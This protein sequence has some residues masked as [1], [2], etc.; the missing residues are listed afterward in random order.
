MTSIVLFTRN[1]RVDDNK[2]LLAAL[3]DKRN[4]NIHCVFAVD[5]EQFSRGG[6]YTSDRALLFLWE[7]LEDL[8]TQISLNICFVDELK[9]AVADRLY[10][11]A[12]FSPFAITREKSLT[13]LIVVNDSLLAPDLRTYYKFTPFYNRC[14]EPDKPIP[15]SPADRRRLTKSKIF[16]TSSAHEYMKKVVS[17]ITTKKTSTGSRSAA[18]EKLGNI[19]GL[20]SGLSP[21]IR[22][23]LVSPRE[24]WWSSHDA[25]GAAASEPVRRQLYWRDFYFKLLRDDPR[26]MTDEHSAT[27]WTGSKADFQ[28]W[29]EGKTK[30]PIVNAAMRQLAAEGDISN[31]LRMLAAYYLVRVAR[32]PWKWGEAY[33]ARQLTDYDWAQNA[34]NWLY[35][36]PGIPWGMRHEFN[37]TLQQQK[38]DPDG[39]YV[40]RWTTQIEDK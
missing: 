27:D 35:F 24:V 2:P 22:F 23:G 15:I 8:A 36:V 11:S 34:G 7:T 1:L 37:L 39:S 10:I 18:L 3:S 17:E 14:A 12:D 28:A 32:C 38:Y 16:L 13:D 20:G 21:Y 5:R 29:T 33:F 30:Y 19:S 31:R 26:L 9:Q 4:S 6:E 40:A 25:L